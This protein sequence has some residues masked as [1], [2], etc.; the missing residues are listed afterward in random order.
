MKTSV[1]VEIDKEQA[2]GYLRSMCEIRNFEERVYELV[3]SGT[4]KGA[5]HLYIGQEAV[6][7]G[8]I[9]AI[10][11]YDLITSTHRGHGHCG[12]IGNL[13]AKSEE[14][15]QEHWNKMLAELMG[16]AT[17]YCKGRGG[18]MHIADVER[19]NVG[20]T[21]IVGGNIPI[22]VGAAMSEH[23]KKSGAVVLCFFGDGA[24]ANG[25]FHEAVNFAAI[26]QLPVVFICENNLYGMSMPYHD[27]SV[28]EA[29]FASPVPTVAERASAY[30]MPGM[31]VNGMDV[32]D[33]KR[34][35]GEAVECARRGEG[36][37]LIEARTYRYMG[38]SMS[39]QQRYRTKEEVEQWR[40]RDPILQL[41]GVLLDHGMATEQELDAIAQRG[42]ETIDHA[43]EFAMNSPFPP[44]EELTEYIYV[45]ED[46]DIKSEALESERTLHAKIRPIENEI[47]QMARETANKSA[48]GTMPK[49]NREQAQELERKHG[50]PIKLYNEALNAAT[51]EEMERDPRVFV[52]GEDIGLYGG[53]YAV[54]RGLFERFGHERIIDTP[55]SELAIAGIGAGAAMRGMRPIVEF[56]YAD[57]LTLGSDQI[58][59]NAAYNRFM[60]GGKTKVP[61]VY[62]S[63]GGVGRC[64]AAHHSESMEAFMMHWP[65]LYVIM[66]ATPFDAK[67]LLK[68]AVR[69]ENPIVFLEHKL[70]YSGVMGPVPDEEYV[71]PIGVADIKKAGKDLTLVA[72]SRQL[73]NALDAMLLLEEQ[74]GIQAEVIDPRTLKPLDV[75]TIAES[76][77]KTGRLV[78]VSEGF[79]I[80]G[81]AGEIMRQ[82]M[83]YE[84]ENGYTGWDYLDAKP[85]LLSGLDCPI[86]MSEPLEDAVVPHRDSIL[87]AVRKWLEGLRDC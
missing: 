66:P 37:T 76:V 27:R 49:L 14:E 71:L 7:V 41:R 44:V 21:G 45:P 33:M 78:I 65:G 85:L 43:A 72:Y 47:R 12:A 6:A 70:L 10:N 58:I 11:E 68:A 51:R 84:F 8:A 25:A 52:M 31:I 60:F 67:G 83:D 34:I 73:H 30:G 26:H 39:D 40:E 64:I 87:E 29:G 57:F 1:A 9:A 20:A 61:L 4:I 3:R 38:H 22:A 62:R 28:P 13:W 19:G 74:D 75:K 81:V 53:A 17:G 2:L 42:K 18:S 23:F 54:T 80:C 50:V 79:P 36:P 35:V 15:R 24:V 77:K 16:R 48:K 56:Q 86:P 5:S 69:N 32:F 55:I 63:Q 46:V 82:V 59:H